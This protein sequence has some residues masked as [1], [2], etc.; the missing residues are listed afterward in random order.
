MFNS[1]GGKNLPADAVIQ[2][3]NKPP[4]S[5]DAS[6]RASTPRLTSL[7]LDVSDSDEDATRRILEATRRYSQFGVEYHSKHSYRARD[8]LS[9]ATDERCSK[10]L[11]YNGSRFKKTHR[12]A[13]C[14][15]A[16]STSHANVSMQ[17]PLH[18]EMLRPSAIIYTPRSTLP[19]YMHSQ[20]P[21]SPFIDMTKG[22]IAKGF[23]GDMNGG[24]CSEP[25]SPFCNV[26][27]GLAS[28]SKIFPS[29]P[30]DNPFESTPGYSTPTTALG[31]AFDS[32]KVDFDGPSSAYSTP[33]KSLASSSS[34]RPSPA[35]LPTPPSILKSAA[36]RI[37]NLLSE[38]RED[39][40]KQSSLS[41]V[42]TSDV[43][44]DTLMRWPNSA[45]MNTEC[46]LQRLR[47]LSTSRQASSHSPASA[48]TSAIQHSGDVVYDS[49]PSTFTQ[50]LATAKTVPI[51]LIDKPKSILSENGEEMD[52][53]QASDSD[54]SSS[55]SPDTDHS[56]TAG[57]TSSNV[58]GGIAKSSSIPR[59]EYTP[60]HVTTAFS[61]S[62]TTSDLASSVSTNSTTFPSCSS[63]G[64]AEIDTKNTPEHCESHEMI[65]KL[66]EDPNGGAKA[67]EKIFAKSGLE[68]G[69]E[70]VES[71]LMAQIPQATWTHIVAP[72][73]QNSSP[74][75]ALTSSF[76]VEVN[77][78]KFSMASN[79]EVQQKWSD[80]QI[81]DRKKHYCPHPTCKKVYT[82][83]SHLKAHMRTHTGE[84]PYACTWQGCEWRFA[85]SDELTR[86]NRK[87]TGD[88]PFQC[89]CCHR[90]FSR[91]DHL[92]LH[93][94]R[95]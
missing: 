13:E 41:R 16:A 87:H 23:L 6:A 62:S 19:P 44:G 53:G 43:D 93:M 17:R 84:R 48:F 29:A 20:I 59:R 49:A 78:E 57:A 94:K 91:S 42:D 85:R 76:A 5:I 45:Q 83:S 60:I 92:S 65:G 55:V 82:K 47:H 67:L 51:K 3:P 63:T 50:N 34:P 36:F 9:I 95:H 69:M 14:S 74:K 40:W 81:I 70:L 35:P 66:L 21:S 58:F 32:L 28:P 15:D 4:L 39:S 56:N 80:A 30:V 86:H 61:P 38:R 24:L 89:Q 73:K 8:H 37:E 79:M 7:L 2:I 18:Q 26:A 22:Q 27:I 64:Q 31:A 46:N 68:K 33:S 90:S 88:R 72:I 12:L 1:R 25:T 11:H 10:I 75:S 54:P 71:A 52:S 77:N